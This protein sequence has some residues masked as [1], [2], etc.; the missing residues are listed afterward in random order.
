MAVTTKP[1]LLIVTYAPYEATET[2]KPTIAYTMGTGRGGNEA[3]DK[4]WIAS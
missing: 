4:P 1:T 3:D 2:L